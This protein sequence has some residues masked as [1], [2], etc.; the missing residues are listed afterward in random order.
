MRYVIA[1][2]LRG[3]VKLFAGASPCGC[4]SVAGQGLARRLI[5]TTWVV[6]S[7]GIGIDRLLRSSARLGSTNIP[8]D[9]YVVASTV[10]DHRVSW[11]V[12][13]RFH[14]IVLGRVPGPSDLN[15]SFV[16]VC[17]W[18]LWICVRFETDHSFHGELVWEHGRSCIV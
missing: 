2:L 6:S 18:V 3:R 10:A 9:W 8:K 11:N 15:E 17:L 12:V 13:N 5:I 7:K 14:G 16:Q 1:L 4:C